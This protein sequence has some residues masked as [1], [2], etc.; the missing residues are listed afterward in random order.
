MYVETY[1]TTSESV[2]DTKPKAQPPPSN[3][4]RKKPRVLDLSRHVRP[5]KND[6]L[7]GRGG[8]TNKHVGNISFHKMVDEL[9]A[10][11]EYDNIEC[12]A[13][14]EK[15][16]RELVE[17]VLKRGRFLEKG[18]DGMWHVVIDGYHTKASQ[19][20]REKRKKGDWNEHQT[21]CT[22]IVDTYVLYHV[23]IT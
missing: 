21:V 13:K 6:V 2:T 23:C 10:K 15:I 3:K 16:A 7:F 12:K 17:F 9:R 22:E 5:T 18:K 1:A 4:K 19:A 8:G 14:K 11:Y 20:L